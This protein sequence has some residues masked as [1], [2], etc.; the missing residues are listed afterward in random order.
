M[1]P[2]LDLPCRVCVMSCL[3]A[4]LMVATSDLP[5]AHTNVPVPSTTTIPGASLAI[6]TGLQP[7]TVAGSANDRRNAAAVNHRPTPTRVTPQVTSHRGGRTQNRSTRGIAK[8]D[9]ATTYKFDIAILGHKV[10][11]WLLATHQLA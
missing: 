11:S 7:P 10:R 8:Q 6:W 4:D 5:V 1:W 3:W 2:G 9:N